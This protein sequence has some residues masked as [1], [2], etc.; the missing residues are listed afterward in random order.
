VGLL[1]C[2][3][4]GLEALVAR[5]VA[6]A[7]DAEQGTGGGE[8]DGAAW[9]TPPT[10]VLKVGGRVLLCAVADLPRDL[11]SCVPGAS[12]TH[13]QGETAFVIVDESDAPPDDTDN[14]PPPEVLRSINGAA[15]RPDEAPG[16][17]G[18]SSEVLCVH[19]A[20]GKRGQHVFIHDILPRVI[21]FVGPHLGLGKTICVAGGDAGIGVALVL[22]Q[23][24]FNDDGRMR[25]GA[26][27]GGAISKSSV[28]TRLEW[29]IAN[30]PHANPPR[31]ILKWV[32]NF[33]LSPHWWGR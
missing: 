14:R 9:R 31:A 22:L 18:N 11:P 10:P 25:D 2:P 21:S 32:N 30:R 16:E 7:Q 24:F 13:L 29:I 8:S 17:S 20:P 1:A 3:R 4:D 19:L 33:L 12:D 27:G 15:A 28:R 5:L 23:F 6:N 26:H